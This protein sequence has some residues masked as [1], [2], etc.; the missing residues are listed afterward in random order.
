ML[1]QVTRKIRTALKCKAGPAIR[2][3]HWVE[4]IPPAALNH[5]PVVAPLV[6]WSLSCL[7]RGVVGSEQST[8][9]QLGSHL[10]K[11]MCNSVNTLSRK[12]GLPH[13]DQDQIPRDFPVSSTF[14]L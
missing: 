6:N 1:E 8:P 10:P 7:A 4:A 2:T 5:S 13:S 3:P 11:S 12:L 14:S 9:S